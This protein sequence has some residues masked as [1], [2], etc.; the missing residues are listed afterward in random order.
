[1]LAGRRD[2]AERRGVVEPRAHERV[3]GDGPLAGGMDLE[4]QVV[5]G[6]LRVAGVAE[7]ADD[8]ARVHLRA[9]LRDRRVGREVPVVEEVARGVAQPLL[10]AA[11]VAP[12]DLHERAVVRREHRRA[13]RCEEVDALVEARVRAG[14]AEVVLEP[15]ASGEREQVARPEQRG[16]ARRVDRRVE[17]VAARR[18]RVAAGGAAV[19]DARLARDVRRQRSGGQ[20]RD[21]AV[22][23]GRRRAAGG[24]SSATAARPCRR[25]RAPRDAADAGIGVADDDLGARGHVVPA[26][27][28]VQLERELRAAVGVGV[29]LRADDALVDRR[30]AEAGDVDARARADAD[31]GAV[32]GD[33]ADRAAEVARGIGRARPRSCGWRRR[34]PRSARCRRAG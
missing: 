34:A 7:E 28:E 20:Q 3:R 23:G 22:V 27:V 15:R 16:L 19:G 14:R 17:R 30:V 32:D 18:R 26:D 13:E 2:A 25:A 10:A 8:V 29:R 1:M 31:R 21:G 12:A 4:V 24:R 9:G 33:G 11:D 5:G 6:A